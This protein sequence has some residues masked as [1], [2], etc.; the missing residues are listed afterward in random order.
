MDTAPT[1]C[2]DVISFVKT[3]DNK[4]ITLFLYDTSGQER[5]HSIAKSFYRKGRVCILVYDVTNRETLIK[6]EYWLNDM[7]ENCEEENVLYICV[8]NKI[9]LPR[10]VTHEEGMEFAQKHQLLYTETSALTCEGVE[11]LF[12]ELMMQAIEN[13]LVQESVINQTQLDSK[14]ESYSCC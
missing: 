10:V 2:A 1:L 12:K 8:G 4:K 14:S 7:K 6:L 11:D 9:D 13:G 5:F 3:Y